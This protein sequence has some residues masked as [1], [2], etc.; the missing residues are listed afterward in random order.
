MEA[1]KAEAV[2][3]FWL[4]RPWTTSEVCPPAS[5]APPPA[6]AT[7]PTAQTL[8]LAQIFAPGSARTQRHGEHPY[9]FTRKLGPADAATLDH[10]YHLLLEGTVSGYPD[11]LPLHCSSEGADHQPI[12][13]YAVTLD[14]V[15]LQDAATGEILASWTD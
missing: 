10:S 15:A 12:C 14:K 4:P 8:G 7:P 1:G 11:G 2:E 5:S 9:S 6:I 3:G 13:I